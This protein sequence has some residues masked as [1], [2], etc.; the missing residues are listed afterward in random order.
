METDSNVYPHD[1]YTYAMSGQLLHANESGQ[2]R[3]I[4]IG[5]VATPGED[6]SSN[7]YTSHPAVNPRTGQVHYGWVPVMMATL[8]AQGITPDFMV[9]HRYPEHTSAANP[10]GSDSDALL[11]SSTAWFSDVAE[12]RQEISDY[13]G[14]GGTNIELVCTENNSDA[15]ALWAGNRPARS[16]AYYAD[17]LSC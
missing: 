11:Q 13:F 9:H 3:T 14:T 1:P 17:S 4:K 7:G 12:L 2:T 10:S 6:S 15:G 5:V 16:T 8:K